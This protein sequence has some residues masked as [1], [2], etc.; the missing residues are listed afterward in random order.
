MTQAKRPKSTVPEY[1]RRE[2]GQRQMA[3]RLS[4]GY[5]ERLRALA[6]AAGYTIGEQLEAL[7]EHEERERAAGHKRRKAPTSR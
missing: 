6:A 4:E 7:I 3:V 1:A 5:P 2:R